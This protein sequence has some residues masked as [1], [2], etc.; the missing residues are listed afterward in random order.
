MSSRK[1]REPEY[2]KKGDTFQITFGRSGDIQYI[3]IYEVIDG[4]GKDKVVI[5][6]KDIRV[7][8]ESDLPI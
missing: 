5:E 8:K 3:A 6:L 1:D 4:D 7:A 2:P